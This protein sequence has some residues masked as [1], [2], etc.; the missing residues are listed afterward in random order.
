MTFRTQAFTENA[1]CGHPASMSVFD[2]GTGHHASIPGDDDRGREPTIHREAGAARQEHRHVAAHRRPRHRRDCLG[3]DRAVPPVLLATPQPA[4][5]P[6]P[7]HP[8]SPS[9]RSEVANSGVRAPSPSTPTTPA[10]RKAVT[11]FA[12]T[13]IDE[14]VSLL[15]EHRATAP[16]A[17]TIGT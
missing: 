4:A 17:A 1:L 14:F 3:P 9:P 11:H 5:S 7:R 13:R 8:C 10:V 2:A 15:V 6:H 12:D 16:L